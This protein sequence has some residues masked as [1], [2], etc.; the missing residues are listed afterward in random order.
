MHE[1]HSIPGAVEESLAAAPPLPSSRAPIA[2]LCHSDE[3]GIFPTRVH[4][5]GLGPKFP[6]STFWPAVSLGPAQRATVPLPELG[7]VPPSGAEAQRGRGG[8]CVRVAGTAPTA[9]LAPPRHRWRCCRNQAT[10]TDAATLLVRHH[11]HR[12]VMTPPACVIANHPPG[13]Q[14]RCAIQR[15]HISIS[16]PT[17]YGRTLAR[18]GSIRPVPHSSFLVPRFSVREFLD[19]RIAHP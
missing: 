12:C 14:S 13:S 2:P 11:V 8:E 9:D 7:T 6:R 4:A 16:H 18:R 17:Q 15:L 1:P 5:G 3:G 19:K 10:G